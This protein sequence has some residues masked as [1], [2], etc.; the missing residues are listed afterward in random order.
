MLFLHHQQCLLFKSFSKLSLLH[1]IKDRWQPSL[2][3]G[4]RWSHCKVLTQTVTLLLVPCISRYGFQ[5]IFSCAGCWCHLIHKSH[6]TQLPF[7]STKNFPLSFSRPGAAFTASHI[8]MEGKRTLRWIQSGKILS[9]VNF[10]AD[11]VQLR[12]LSLL[13]LHS[14][15]VFDSD[16]GR[17]KKQREG[18][19]CLPDVCVL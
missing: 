8:G 14:E 10:G 1:C 16:S 13:R 5:L 17:G 2:E 9:S 3:S 15:L 12:L 7:T 6:L 18:K 4:I 19:R 11:L